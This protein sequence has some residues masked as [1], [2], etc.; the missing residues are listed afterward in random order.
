MAWRP[1]PLART[2]LTAVAASLPGNTSEA[3][4]RSPRETV[5]RFR[6]FLQAEV[7]VLSVTSRQDYGVE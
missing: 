2:R 6:P 7:G 1:A 4:S 5:N 3:L